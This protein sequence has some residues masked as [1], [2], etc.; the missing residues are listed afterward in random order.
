M[1]L[2]NWFRGH[3]SKATVKTKKMVDDPFYE[4]RRNNILP[5]RYEYGMNCF[6][7]TIY[8][9]EGKQFAQL[10]YEEI[11]N[12]QYYNINRDFHEDRALFSV[13]NLY[14]G[15]E[16]Y[17]KVAK[18][19]GRA[20]RT[21]FIVDKKDFMKFLLERNFDEKEVAVVQTGIITKSGRTI[22]HLEPLGNIGLDSDRWI[23]KGIDLH[24]K[25]RYKEAIENYDKAIK[26]E[27][28]DA[29]AWHN[30]AASLFRQE[31]Y[32]EAVECCHKTL[33]ITPKLAWVWESKS[34]ILF[35]MGKKIE[36]SKCLREAFKLDPKLVTK[37][38]K[39]GLIETVSW[40]DKLHEDWVKEGKEPDK[41]AHL[42]L[43]KASEFLN[44]GDHDK[45]LLCTEIA[46]EINPSAMI[47]MGDG[48]MVT[49]GELAKMIKDAR[50]DE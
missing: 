44:Q 48:K 1:S 6:V 12:N 20:E 5:E 29:R 26:A 27:P 47:L 35:Q 8:E 4:Y 50:S 21:A 34:C 28:L 15:K 23:A 49:A 11:K 17:N 14:V 40:V 9:Q 18:E 30:K 10:F 33:E 37:W 41:D 25:G 3:K 19:L 31:R 43:D 22:S 42:W 7:D 16:A 46:A 38:E 32:Q 39:Y 13:K 24:K 36:A 45:F 2:L